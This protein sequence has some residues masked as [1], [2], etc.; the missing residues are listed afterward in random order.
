MIKNYRLDSEYLN[1]LEEIQVRIKKKK[2]YENFDVNGTD[3]IKII[4]DNYYESMICENVS[5]T[6]IEQISEKVI[7][8]MDE[9]IKKNHR[10]IELATNYFDETSMI[11]QVLLN[12]LLEVIE[13]DSTNLHENI[14]DMKFIELA[15]EIENEIRE[16]E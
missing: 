7:L 5:E 15:K 2:E 1:K 3:V 16:K 14:K 10:M 13:V 9:E 4:I 12:H 6:Y 8:K 11:N